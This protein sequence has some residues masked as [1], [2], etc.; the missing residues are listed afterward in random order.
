MKCWYNVNIG[1]NRIGIITD[2][3]GLDYFEIQDMETFE[4]TIKHKSK[5]ELI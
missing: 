3:F 2:D 1:R 4:F 5:I